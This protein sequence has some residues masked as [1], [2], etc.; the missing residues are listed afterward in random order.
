VKTSFLTNLLGDAKIIGD[1]DLYRDL[2][3]IN[4]KSKVGLPKYI[5]PG[6]VVTVSAISW[7]VEKGISIKIDKKD[8][9]HC[10]GLDSQKVHKKGLFGSGFLISE[11]AAAEKAAA[12]KAAAEKAAAEKVN[13]ITWELSEKE[14]QV[15]RSLG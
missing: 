6:N 14:W 9:K 13:I 15:I 11:K 1:A 7:M 10:R 3:Q 5:Y 4:E 8:A 12:E 2:A